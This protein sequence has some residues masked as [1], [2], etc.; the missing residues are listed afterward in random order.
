MDKTEVKLKDQM[1]LT[2]ANQTC[3]SE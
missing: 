1:M 3:I 2:T